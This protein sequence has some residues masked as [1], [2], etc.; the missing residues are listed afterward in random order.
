MGA[1]PLLPATR[2]TADD[3]RQWIGRQEGAVALTGFGATAIDRDDLL[4]SGSSATADHADIGVLAAL[5]LRGAGTSPPRPLYL[6]A[7][8]ARPQTGKAVEH[9]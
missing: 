6:R 2:M 1:E 8:D 5:A 3:V 9:A 7:P 4:L